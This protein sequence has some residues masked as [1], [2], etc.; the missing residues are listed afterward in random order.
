MFECLLSPFRAGRIR[1]IGRI[2]RRFADTPS[3]D[4]CTAYLNNLFGGRRANLTSARPNL[5]KPPHAQVAELVDAL[6]SGASDLTVVKV[7]VLSWAPLP[8]YC[9]TKFAKVL[10]PVNSG[11]DAEPGQYL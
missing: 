7:R 2:F 6:A 8:Q 10:A 5:N 1:L 3:P 11:E 9:I 4:F